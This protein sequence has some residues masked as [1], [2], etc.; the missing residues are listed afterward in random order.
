[1]RNIIMLVG[2]K[3]CGKTQ[4]GLALKARVPEAVFTDL[5]ALVE[6]RAGK[7]V[8]ELYREGPE[9]FRAAERDALVALLENESAA[10]LIIAAGGGLID[11]VG[12]LEAV[13]NAAG[14]TMVY[15][16]TAAETAWRRIQAAGSLPPFL[17]TADPHATH[18]LLHERRAA[19]YKQIAALTVKT[20]EK[21][22]REIA[23]YIWRAIPPLRRP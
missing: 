14:L 23:G 22:P 21:F 9:L 16:E 20:G 2:P 4:A 18:L 17:Q 11:N 1:V 13:K 7:T 5:D 10:P 8:R 3:H 12:A 15:L 6:S 19:R